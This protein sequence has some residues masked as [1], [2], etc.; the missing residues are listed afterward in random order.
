MPKQ[1][2]QLFVLVDADSLHCELVCILHK[3]QSEGILHTFPQ[4][5]TMGC[6]SS[7]R[8]QS[9]RSMAPAAGSM[10]Q[11]RL[12]R[13]RC[14]HLLRDLL[15]GWINTRRRNHVNLRHRE[16]PQPRETASAPCGAVRAVC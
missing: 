6:Q 16:Q 14:E 8:A 12:Y 1:L 3:L 2:S 11:G 7:I 15:G 5:G 4:T 10:S 9:M 13:E